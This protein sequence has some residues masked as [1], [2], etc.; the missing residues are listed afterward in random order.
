MTCSCVNFVAR[1]VIGMRA[2]QRASGD[3]NEKTKC[4]VRPERYDPVRHG[5]GQ[6]TCE[7]RRACG[8]HHG[9][10]PPIAPGWP[11]V[12]PHRSR[13]PAQVLVRGSSRGEG[14]SDREPGVTAI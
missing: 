1:E 9:A 6:H 11:L 8:V 7:W 4:V 13:E 10:E 2:E 14:S 12:L 3:T 5:G